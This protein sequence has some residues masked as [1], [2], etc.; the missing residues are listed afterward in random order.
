MMR[1]RI[2]LTRLYHTCETS[3][4]RG[5]TLAE[6]AVATVI[7]FMIVGV[8]YFF[9]NTYT[10]KMRK[11]E[12]DD[13]LKMETESVMKAVMKDISSILDFKKDADGSYRLM[14]C[15]RD[16]SLEE[17]HYS[18]EEQ[19]NGTKVINRV[20]KGVSNKVAE[21]I[22][23]FDITYEEASY[24]IDVTVSTIGIPV[25]SEEV[26]THKLTRTA[27]IR[28]RLL[29][30]RQRFW[31]SHNRT[32]AWEASGEI[33]LAQD[34][35]DMA[36]QF[37]ANIEG[38]IA[39]GEAS[40]RQAVNG[41]QQNIEELRSSSIPGIDRGLKEMYRNVRWSVADLAGRGMRSVAER[42]G[43]KA[44]AAV[45]IDDLNGVMQ[46]VRSY[47]NNKLND[48]ANAIDGKIKSLQ[49]VDE[50]EEQHEQLRNAGRGQGWE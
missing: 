46:E 4:P 15:L 39:Q 3:G 49:A 34:L 21:S 47:G 5:F 13:M 1:A 17:V 26:R 37:S 48:V 6:I 2:R 16:E 23:E 44:A 11:T 20:F 27:Y 35:E 36:D 9:L 12:C 40:F 33:T 19:E 18:L 28:E 38:I 8:A 50:L 24:K 41:L 7:F 10:T 45:G 29:A 42:L 30:S 22:H 25:G 32:D 14:I 43:R 31:V